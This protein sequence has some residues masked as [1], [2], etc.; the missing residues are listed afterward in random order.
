[1]KT[2]VESRRRRR[3][4]AIFRRPRIAPRATIQAA[5]PINTVRQQLLDNVLAA[6]RQLTSGAA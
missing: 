6:L 4:R 5:A 3:L 1:M 2:P